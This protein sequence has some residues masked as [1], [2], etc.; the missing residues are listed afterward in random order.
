MISSLRDCLLTAQEQFRS[1]ARSVL[2][3]CIPRE[4]LEENFYLAVKNEFLSGVHTAYVKEIVRRLGKLMP[5]QQEQAD[6][7]GLKD[8]TSISKMNSSGTIDGVRLTAILCLYP[9]L[10]THQ[11]IRKRATLHGFARATSF[12]KAQANHK[13]TIKE[14][15][16]PQDFSYVAGVLASSEWAL[17]LRSPDP[18]VAREVAARIVRQWSL[19]LEATSRQ[20]DQ[21]VQMLRGL[22]E[23]WAEFVV[24]TLWVIPECIPPEDTQ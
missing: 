22:Y 7:L 13:A 17:A 18:R 2:Q 10:I 11:A 12:I 8:R 5:T 15:M 19:T 20:G 21:N 6:A 9:D 24:A 3:R 16:S 23:D 14:T 1:R 4:E